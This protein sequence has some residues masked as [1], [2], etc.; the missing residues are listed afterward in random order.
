MLYAL[1]ALKL[2]TP[3]Y[4]SAIKKFEIC[5][6]QPRLDSH[7]SWF[8]SVEELLAW[9]NEVKP[10][11]QKAFMGLGEYHAGEWCRFCR[12]NGMCKAQ[13]D[14]HLSAFEDFKDVTGGDKPYQM[15]R[16][17]ILTPAQMADVLERGKSLV[18]W[19]DSVKDI[20]LETI[21]AG[22]EVPGWKAVE[23]RSTRE[24][25][26]QDK[27]LETL[28]AAGVDRAVI[29]DNVPKSLAQLEKLLGKDKFN[30]L[31]GSLVVK[32]RGKPA[33]ATIDDKRKN[34]NSAANDFAA[35]AQK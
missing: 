15:R 16:S 31:V 10:K 17:A 13:A 26:D 34:Y 3:I 9:G 7:N 29:Y 33:L 24:W 6:D 21:L 1:G 4:G 22:E 19:Y 30:E 32:P 8:C 14:Q 12:A 35:V 18:A 11:A 5:I 28:Q 2:Y 23:G 20:A 25:S 27:A